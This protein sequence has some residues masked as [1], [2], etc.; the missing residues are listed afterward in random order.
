MKD[1]AILQPHFVDVDKA[2]EYL[3]AKRWPDGPICPH[4]GII[5]EAYRLEADLENK[6][7]TTHARKGLLKCAACRKQFS[8][9][10]GTIFEDS[11]IPLNKWLMAYHL[12]CASKKGISAHQLHRMLGISYK[13]AWFMCH[14]VRYTM[15]QQPLAGMLTGTVEVDETYIGGKEQ[16]GIATSYKSKKQPVLAILERQGRVLAFP[17]EHVTLNNIEPVLKSYIAPDAKLMTDESSVYGR[18]AEYFASHDRVN[19]KRKEYSRRENGRTITTNS[20]EGFFS[21]IKRGN[22]GTFHH[23][24]RCYTQQYLNE[25]TFRYGTRKMTDSERNNLALKAVDGKRLMLKEPKSAK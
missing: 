14:R 10:V 3:E 2:R 21:L 23:W 7:A 4:C 16:K 18:P 5:G 8:V 24:K 20:V 25:F 9:T 11:K 19:H 15:T 6:K 17:I 12:M 1:A 22:Y 13:S